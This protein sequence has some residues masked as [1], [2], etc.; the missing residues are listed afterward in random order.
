MD[1]NKTLQALSD[2][3]LIKLFDACDEYIPELCN[4]IWE[5]VD[6]NL[7]WKDIDSETFEDALEY[8]I[9]KLEKTNHE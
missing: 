5:R 7:E 3:E 1:S 6:I 8:A 9:Q 4:E 2:R